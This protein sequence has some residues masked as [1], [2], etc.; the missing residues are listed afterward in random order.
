MKCNKEQFEAV[1]GKLPKDKI[2]CISD[3]E[4]C[5]YLTNN[6]GGYLITISNIVERDKH[7]RDREIHETWN[8][9]VFLEACGIEPTF[10]IT[11]ETILKYEMRDEFPSVFKKELEVG[12]W[13]KVIDLT[14]QFKNSKGALV[15][16]S[17]GDHYG[18]GYSRE[19]WTT[20]F[21]NLDEVIKRDTDTVIEATDQEV[22]EAL[23]NEAVKRYDLGEL[24][25]CLQDKS[26]CIAREGK[27]HF[28]TDRFYLDYCQ[29]LWMYSSE[30]CN[31]KVFEDGI[32]ATIIPTITKK[33][34]EEILGKKI[35]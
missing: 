7:D 25:S 27:I 4:T 2:A 23:K 24:I 32:W 20:T 10:T 35:I 14:G 8:E 13:Y 12:K 33:E 6:L 1:K 3:F 16:Y 30:S 28:G 29:Q 34:A 9:K 26:E 15:S 5:I 22:F 11:K 17:K 19:N 21:K 31:I 18:F